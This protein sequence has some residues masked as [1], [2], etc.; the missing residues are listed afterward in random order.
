MTVYKN[1]DG[2]VVGQPMSPFFGAQNGQQ[3]PGAIT[4]EQPTTAPTAG[5]MQATG[6][7][8]SVL[9]QCSRGL[10]PRN[11]NLATIAGQSVSAGV[12]QSQGDGLSIDE[13]FSCGNGAE[14]C[15]GAPVAPNAGNTS[16]VTLST[17]SNQAFVDGI[18]G[19]GDAISTGPAAT[20][21]ESVVSAP[22]AHSTTTASVTLVSGVY[23]G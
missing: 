7:Q 23:S 18:A 11:A 22:M 10:I 16:V 3:G 6:V 21:I 8:M 5:G 4:I 2:I 19:A 14:T 12:S 9:E 15:L 17:L 20:N 1:T 13:A